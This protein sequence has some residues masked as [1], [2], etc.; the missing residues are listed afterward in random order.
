MK[1]IAAGCSFSDYLQDN[2]IVWG[3]ALA[4][5]LKAD[6]IHEGAG[7][8]SNYRIWRRITRHVLDRNITS[9]DLVCIQYTGIE[10]REFWSRLPRI[11][12]EN[13]P[14][15]IETREAW[16][17][18]D[19]GFIMRFKSFSHEWQDHSIESQFHK[20]LEEN[21]IC[22]SHS[23]EVFQTNHHMFQSMLEV[24]KIPTVFMY[25]RNIFP[26]Y[27]KVSKYHKKL[28]FTESRED[29]KNKKYWYQET[30]YT[31]LSDVGHENMADQ[32]YT[33]LEKVGYFNK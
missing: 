3:E 22:N 20:L 23:L 11:F 7:C 33:H 9:K 5:K 26:E 18:E 6:Y 10:R 19:G 29:A 25:V 32:I 28:A 27:L 13:G 8:G 30:D 15:Q 24:H 21:F 14:K 16:T 4:K 2:N 12:P 31:H 1:V 17:G